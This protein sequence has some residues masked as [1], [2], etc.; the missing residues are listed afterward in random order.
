MRRFA[1]KRRTFSR[2]ETIGRSSFDAKMSIPTE[3]TVHASDSDDEVEIQND[4]FIEEVK[5][6]PA[7]WNNTLRPYHDRNLKTALWTEV[8]EVVIKNW[9]TLTPDRME[10]VCKYTQLM[11]LSKYNKYILALIFSYFIYTTI[12]SIIYN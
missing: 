11:V 9:Y 8:A 1:A 7:L 10:R 12:I 5:K 6:R 4:I 3:T 2:V